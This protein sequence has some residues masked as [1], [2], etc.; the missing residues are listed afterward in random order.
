MKNNLLNAF[1]FQ[2]YHRTL[3]YNNPLKCYVFFSIYYHVAIQMQIPFI[4]SLCDKHLANALSGFKYSLH[5]SFI[6]AKYET[7]FF[8]CCFLGYI[9]IY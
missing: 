5:E 9:I 4:I 6:K 7:R 1:S 3:V 2:A 8:H